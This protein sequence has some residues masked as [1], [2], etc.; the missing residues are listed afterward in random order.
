LESVE[1]TTGKIEADFWIDCSG[2]ARVLIGP[3]GGGWKSFSEY[4]P[5]NGAIPYIH[6]FK[7][8]EDVRLETLA[9]AQPNG[10][11]WQIPTQKRYGCG[12]VYSDMFTTYDKAVDE[13]MKTTGRK[14][15][16][17]RNLKFDSGRLEKCWVD[18]VV[19]I[20]L[21]AAF[22]EPL[23]ATSIHS[24]V[25]QLDMLLASCLNFKFYE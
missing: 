20:G 13:L 7:K 9:W 1:T 16:P 21:S 11:M 8:D 5:V 4:L 24:T 6:E 12:Y 17:L 22:V 25:V 23:E 14:I 19:G 3:M 10:W 18:N 15:E 2:F